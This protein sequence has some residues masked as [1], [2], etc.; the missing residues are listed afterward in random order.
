MINKKLRKYLARRNGN[1]ILI[2]SWN[3]P[4]EGGDKG[5]VVVLCGWGGDHTE[6]K[7]QKRKEIAS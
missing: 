6:G 5:G 3:K 1:N 7:N 2:R 4:E